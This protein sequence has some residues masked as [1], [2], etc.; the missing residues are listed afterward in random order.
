M[1]MND[2]TKLD[3]HWKKHGFPQYDYKANGPL[4]MLSIMGA[5]RNIEEMFAK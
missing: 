5:R 2:K 3:Y 1:D 4:K